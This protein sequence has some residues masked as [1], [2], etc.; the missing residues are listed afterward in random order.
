VNADG[1]ID[2]V[3]PI[4]VD[5][6][7]PAVAVGV[8]PGLVPL[9]KGN[10]PLPT[11]VTRPHTKALVFFLHNPD[12]RVGDTPDI[13]RDQVVTV[14]PRRT[15]FAIDVPASVRYGHAITVGGT[16][17]QKIG[18]AIRK[19][20]VTLTAR[21][22]GESAYQAVATARTDRNGAV[23]VTVRPRKNTT[24]RWQWPGAAGNSA[25]KSPARAV[26]VHQAVTLGAKP[27]SVKREHSFQLYGTTDPLVRGARISVQLRKHGKW[28]TVRTITTHEQQLPNGVFEAGY[29]FWRSE[30]TAGTYSFRAKWPAT[31]GRSGGT[32]K[33]V[34]V[35]VR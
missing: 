6:V 17:Q 9:F 34:Q 3:G 25:V 16:L 2:S 27:G 20:T 30:K 35:T 28:E 10:G 5:A 33:T 1:N 14:E 12:D 29:K 18:A 11:N 7:D 13:D 23:S 32:S 19:A 31:S 15:S 8:T 26:A 22:A 4:T 24:Y 21:Q